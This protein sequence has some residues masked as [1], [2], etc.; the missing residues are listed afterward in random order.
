MGEEVGHC[1]GGKVVGDEEGG[2]ARATL[3]GRGG[4]QVDVFGVSFL[5]HG[6]FY[7]ILSYLSN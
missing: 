1:G 2:V 4:G 7:N 5:E 6:Y 3:G